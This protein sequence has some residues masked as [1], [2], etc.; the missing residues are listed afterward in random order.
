MEGDDALLVFDYWR[1]PAGVLHQAVSSTRKQVYF[2]VSH[3]HQDH[4][5]PEILSW[6]SAVPDK[7]HRLLVSYDTV[8]RRH[9]PKEQLAA[10]L[11]PGYSYSDDFVEVH[12][13]RSSDI[14]V[15]VGVTLKG[16]GATLF[17]AGD[18]NNWYFA[19]TPDEHLKVSPQQMEALFLSIL[20]DIKQ[21]YPRFSHVM[22][23][24]D[25][26]LGAE[27]MRGP[28]QWLATIATDHFHPMHQ[29]EDGLPLS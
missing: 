10:V 16:C 11:R 6:P 5:N 8:R 12:A 1:D 23:P 18:L 22:F 26:R 15:S 24:V 9:V 17:H 25:P 29:W 27:M 19:D 28:Q 4:Y 21:I 20:R 2:F 7:P 14:G 13:F 3:F